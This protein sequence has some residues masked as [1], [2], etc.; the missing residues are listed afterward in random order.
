[1]KEIGRELNVSESA[2]SQLH[3]RALKLMAKALLDSGV[4]S[5]SDLR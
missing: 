5:C 4:T 3:G 2:V 1:M